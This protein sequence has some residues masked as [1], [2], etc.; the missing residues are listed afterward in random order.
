MFGVLA[1]LLACACFVLKVQGQSA[2][3]WL[4]WAGRPE[5]QRTTHIPPDNNHTLTHTRPTRHDSIGHN[6]YLCGAFYSYNR[7][8]C[9][10]Y[11]KYTTHTHTR[12]KGDRVMTGEFERS[13]SLS[14]QA[15]LTLLSGTARFPAAPAQQSKY[16]PI[17]Y[18]PMGI[19]LWRRHNIM[20]RPLYSSAPAGAQ[21][22]ITYA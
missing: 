12:T 22:A 15:T 11:Y 4:G 20:R 5:N 1:L 18:M 6:K 7:H 19:H 13:L 2:Y 3:H 8:T 17:R 21:N 9:G 14:L 16:F 10:A